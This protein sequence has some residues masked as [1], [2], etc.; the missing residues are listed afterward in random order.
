[1]KTVTLFVSICL[2]A[3]SVSAQSG[4]HAKE[5]KAAIKAAETWL[6]LV[7]SGS[8]DDSWDEAAEFFQTNTTKESW[9]ETLTGLM[10]QFGQV[11]SREVI[12]S[13]FLTKMPGGPDGEYV[14]IQFKTTFEKKA[15]AVETVTPQKD[16]KGN[17]RVCGYYIK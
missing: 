10:P 9:N 2:Y 14:M 16:E 6:K 3:V 7:D 5:E 11:K 4:E 12:K 13:R 15:D 1:M 17:W 8:Y